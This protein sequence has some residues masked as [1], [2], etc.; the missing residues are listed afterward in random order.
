MSVLTLPVLVLNTNWEPLNDRYTVEAALVDMTREKGRKWGE[1]SK[2]G[3]HVELISN[4]EGGYDLGPGT[5]PVEW[6]EW[7]TLP[8]RTDHHED[9]AVHTH[10]Y[11]WRAP[12]VIICTGYGKMPMKARRLSSETIRERDGGICQYTGEHVGK[13]GGNLD[14]VIPR[15]RGGK[16]TFENLVWSKKQV[17]YD[18][19][20]R[21]NSEVGLTLIRPPKAPKAVPAS[22]M[23]KEAKHVQWLPFLIR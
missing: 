20:N 23:I 8:V 19:G 21:L 12:S 4:D 1:P 16:D 2:I 10:L 6:D 14:H 18:K 9:R 7:I 3:M 22:A 13:A 15:D 17:N 5:R 11:T